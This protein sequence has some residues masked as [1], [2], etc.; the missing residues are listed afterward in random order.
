MLAL[1]GF[2]KREIIKEVK[3]EIF[4][5]GFCL[6]ARLQIFKIFLSSS[7]TA[8]VVNLP[9]EKMGIIVKPIFSH[10]LSSLAGYCLA[11]VTSILYVSVHSLKSCLFS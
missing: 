1:S 10:F 2:K 7:S 8:Y 5:A 3:L 11:L 4:H 9:L 6:P